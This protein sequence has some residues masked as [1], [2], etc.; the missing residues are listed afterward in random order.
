MEQPAD[1]V[2]DFAEEVDQPLANS[3]ELNQMA[4]ILLSFN[5][6]PL[7]PFKVAFPVQTNWGAE[8][9]HQE[10]IDLVWR[11]AG[12]HLAQLTT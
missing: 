7:P 9:L 2:V 4:E 8:P 6:D 12:I 5:G 11:H 1:I 3:C 10:Q